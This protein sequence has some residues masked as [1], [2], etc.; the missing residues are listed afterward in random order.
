MLMAS[1]SPALLHSSWPS[2]LCFLPL[3]SMVL[4]LVS[5]G[6]VSLLVDFMAMKGYL[7]RET[8]L[9]ALRAEVSRAGAGSKSSSC[10]TEE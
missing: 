6:M 2:L 3:L 8:K 5:L 4:N 1:Q 9:L 7:C 10:T